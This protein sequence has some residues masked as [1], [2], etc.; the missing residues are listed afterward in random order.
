MAV[1]GVRDQDKLD[2]ASNFV[3]WK[4][5][6]LFVLDR[7][8]LKQFTLRAIAVLVDPAD[9]DKYEDA[10]ARAKSIVLDAVKDHVLRH[11][12]EKNTTNEMW[13]ALKMLYQH[14]FV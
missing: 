10:M 4:A 9:N 7:N 6:I 14:T 1:N 8:R 12:A 13:E 2:R 3:V 5:K 11:I